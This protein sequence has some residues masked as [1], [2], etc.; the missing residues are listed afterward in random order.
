[1][2]WVLKVLI[3]ILHAIYSLFFYNISNKQ[4]V[5]HP[6]NMFLLNIFLDL[7]MTQTML[8]SS[9]AH[10][11]DSLLNLSLLPSPLHNADTYHS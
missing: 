5:C 9:L 10:H 2:P 6:F 4:Y 11:G 3:F 1:M 8:S 7:A